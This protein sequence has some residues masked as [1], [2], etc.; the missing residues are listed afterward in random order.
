MEEKRLKVLEFYSGIGGMHYAL[1]RTGV[2]FDV[3]GAF[4][5]NTSANSVYKHNF[6][7]VNLL[8]KN[9]DGLQVKYLESFGADVWTMSPPCQPYTRQGKQ[10][11]SRDA[12]AQSF[13]NL[14]HILTHM[15]TPPR[16]LFVENV[17]GFECSDT[18]DLLIETLKA[19]GYAYQD[20]LL[21]PSDLGVPNSRTRYY[22][23]GRMSAFSFAT[24]PTPVLG[25][26]IG[27]VEKNE[28]SPT[29]TTTVITT[30]AVVEKLREILCSMN[31][32]SGDCAHLSDY[33]EPHVDGHEHALNNDILLRYHTALDIAY[34]SESRS[35]CFTKGYSR[36]VVGTGSVVTRKSKQ[37]VE[38]VYAEVAQ[39]EDENRKL[40]LLSSLQ[41]RYFS[42]REVCNLMCFPHD[43][44]FPD[45]TTQ[46]QKYM[47]LGN[48]VNVFVIGALMKYI[49]FPE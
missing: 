37:D 28:I 29:T 1:C 41:L 47:L 6:P 35:C 44:V 18:R 36:Y 45:T 15:T 4:D 9:I 8:Q 16:Y 26:G 48:S 34:L 7:H 23:V 43:F 33:I 39:T 13:L 22:L 11:E 2:Q 20:F 24:S 19:R 40:E 25:G 49:L 21:S 12:R 3:V 32:N 38:T 27:R 42:P 46:K 5:I 10:E 14:L 17:K 31:M 30:F